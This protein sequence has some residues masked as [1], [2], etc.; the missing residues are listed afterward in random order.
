MREPEP[1]DPMSVEEYGGLEARAGFRHLRA[2]GVWWRR[3]KPLFYRPLFPFAP[4]PSTVEPPPL[5][6]LGGWQHAVA[7]NEPADSHLNYMVFTDLRSYDPA[8]LKR[9]DRKNLK[10]AARYLTLRR[11]SDLEEFASEGLRILR[12][13]FS[14]STYRFRRDRLRPEVFR[15]WAEALISEPRVLVLGAYGPSGLCEVHISLRVEH[16]LL[17]DVAFASREGRLFRSSDAVL[18][19]LRRR[20]AQTDAAYV[21]LGSVG[22]KGTLDGFKLRRGAEILS[23]PARLHLNPL[24]AAALRLATPGIFRRLHGMDEAAALAYSAAC[25][26]A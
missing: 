10:R 2:A 19:H 14:R 17:F 22:G 23:L 9:E 18:D 12:E 25:P 7:G 3:T 20:A 24:A 26:R 21:C 6:R 1:W 8:R 4:L 5:A 16:V 13:F 15:R 11:V